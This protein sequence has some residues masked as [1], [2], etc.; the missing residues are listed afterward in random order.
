MRGFI[1]LPRQ[2]VIWGRERQG[3]NTASFSS[4]F[5]GSR[6]SQTSTWNILKV[7][8]S[9]TVPRP[10]SL[11]HCHTSLS[12][13]PRL[14]P[15]IQ[16]SFPRVLRNKPPACKSSSRSQ[17]VACC[18]PLTC[19]NLILPWFSLLIPV[20]WPEYLLVI[21]ISLFQLILPIFSPAL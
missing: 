13:P 19:S 18:Q 5:L 3:V 6:A 15:P 21:T 10:L 2:W 12:A 9:F 17:S 11:E 14:A 1:T 16:V 20:T 8:P 7:H 4:G